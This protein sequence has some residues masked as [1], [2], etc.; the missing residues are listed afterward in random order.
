MRTGV[1]VRWI[2]TRYHMD[3]LHVSGYLRLRNHEV[4][5]TSNVE[6]PVCHLCQFPLFL[7]TSLF[8]SF[9]A[10]SHYSICSITNMKINANF[11]AFAAMKFDP[12]KYI[13]S[14]SYGVNRFM[15]DRIGNEKARA[16]TIVE[17]RPNSSFPEHEHIGG[18][19]F[20]VL[21][22]TFKDQFGAFP[23]GTYVRNPIGSKHSPWVDEDGC[24]IMVKLLQMAETGEGT[25]PLHIDFEKEKGAITEFGSVLE[26]YKN[27]STGERVQMIRLNPEVAFPIDPLAEGGEELFVYDGSLRILDEEYVQWGWL[28]FP[29]GPPMDNRKTL[30]AGEHGACV[31]RKT[32][33]LTDTAMGM[34]RIQIDLETEDVIDD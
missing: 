10:S 22:G 29:P 25:T 12:S 28:R 4:R 14:P 7:I 11:D 15:L 23:A 3:I 26:M 19:E 9:V 20:L 16:T 21:K 17:Y 34:E 2:H 33:H 8:L 1:R 18:E 31:Y 30:A 5:R 13:S 24:V 27:D 32:G 6:H